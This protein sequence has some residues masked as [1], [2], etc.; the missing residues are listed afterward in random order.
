MKKMFFMLLMIVLIFT[1]SSCKENDTYQLN[2]KLAN[3]L[4][5][6]RGL[7][8]QMVEEGEYEELY[9]THD[10]ITVRVL[11]E[12]DNLY[13]NLIEFYSYNEDTYGYN[14]NSCN[15]SED[16]LDCEFREESLLSNN[17]PEQQITLEQF[18]NAIDS[19][20]I[21]EI[22]SL[23]L[24]TWESTIFNDDYE[25]WIDIFQFDE[26]LLKYIPYADNITVFDD[27]YITDEEFALNGY[28]LRIAIRTLDY[29]EEETIDAYYPFLLGD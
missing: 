14:V 10:L 28:Y 24:S 29:G 15:G 4:N 2:S 6:I 25:I 16:K 20:N 13:A 5:D 3:G 18:S 8:N 17:K 1:L 26:Q 19:V 7:F 11:V 27:G 12:S 21:E 22:K 23:N 9:V